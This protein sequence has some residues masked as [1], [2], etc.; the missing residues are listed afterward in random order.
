MVSHKQPEVGSRWTFKVDPTARVW[1]VTENKPGGVVEYRQE[2]RLRFG[3]SYLRDWYANAT[4]C[5]E[6]ASI[7]NARLVAE[8]Q[9]VTIGIHLVGLDQL[10]EVMR[11]YREEA[12]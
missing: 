11:T 6:S 9:A 12:R 1:I 7:S 10:P 4:P 8:L 3:R 5:A 2:D